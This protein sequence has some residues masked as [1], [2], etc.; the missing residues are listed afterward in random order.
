MLNGYMEANELIPAAEAVEGFS[1]F[2]T[3]KLL[4]CAFIAAVAMI[5]PGLPSQQRRRGERRS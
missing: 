5:I 2:M 3:V 4:V 1:A